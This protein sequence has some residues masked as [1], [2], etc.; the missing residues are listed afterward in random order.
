M[1]YRGPEENETA[2][3]SPALTADLSTKLLARKYS[4]GSNDLFR[5]CNPRLARVGEKK[6][7]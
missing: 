4:P 7:G 3:R 6:G 1:C 5:R 2:Q